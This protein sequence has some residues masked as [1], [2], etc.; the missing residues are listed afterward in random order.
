M[1]PD[2]SY[3]LWLARF[4]TYKQYHLRFWETQVDWD[5][6]N[7]EISLMCGVSNSTVSNWRKKLTKKKGFRNLKFWQSVDWSK[8]NVVIARETG[9]SASQVCNWRQRLRKP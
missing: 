1:N 6:S 7:V 3:V 4:E 8:R 9:Q 2:K 5:L